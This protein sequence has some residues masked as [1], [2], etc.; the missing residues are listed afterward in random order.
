M[1][2]I[3]KL[4]SFLVL[5]VSSC[6]MVAKP[7]LC[8]AAEADKLTIFVTGNILS[9]LKPCGCMEEQLGGFERRGVIFN[10]APAD[11]R[12]I[13][14]SGNMIEKI[15]EQDLI[16]FEIIM[17]AL[18]LLDYDLV[19]FNRLDL[20]AAEQ[21]GLLNQTAVQ[22]IS[23]CSHDD[24][25][26]PSGFSR[27]FRLGDADLAVTVATFDIETAPADQISELFAFP[28]SAEGQVRILLLNSYDRQQIMEI[29]AMNVAD[30][31]IC[32]TGSD[33]PEVLNNSEFGSLVVSVGRLGEYIGRISVV[34][35]SDGR[36]K[37]AYT[38]QAVAENLAEDKRLV[39]L[40]QEYQLIVRDAKLLENYPRF[41][42]PDGLEYIDS[43]AC[44]ICHE[45]RYNNEMWS[46][47]KHSRAFATLEKV[48]S[49]YDPE[50]VICHT[51]GMEYEQGFVNE[52]QTP[53][54]KNVGCENCHGPGSEH[55]LT[56]GKAKTRGPLSECIDCHTP[57]R[58]AEFIEKEQWYRQ[59][60]VH[61]LEPNTVSIVE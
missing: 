60:I 50:C 26:F 36:V 7:S 29:A 54:F 46:K 25:N 58:S 39:E 3:I 53:E 2:R 13:L 49:Q 47:R 23:C 59:E 42:L 55:M 22:V 19:N 57:Q 51:V 31:I 52:I 43:G 38:W 37:L 16:K 1:N 5:C 33:E 20:D 12:L 34:Y 10:S 45:H 6:G 15:S 18:A 61:W 14:D 8:N 28:D 4:L 35:G 40:Y 11:K 21:S 17:R 24:V 56:L 9:S 44:G 41:S 32:P 48:G 27:K 30:V